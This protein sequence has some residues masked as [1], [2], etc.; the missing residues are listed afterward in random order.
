MLQQSLSQ[1]ALVAGTL[2]EGKAEGKNILG[3]ELLFFLERFEKREG[4]VSVDID[5]QLDGRL[6]PLRVRFELRE[7]EQEFVLGLELG[8]LFKWR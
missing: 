1:V 3:L 5:E 4:G 7:G 6:W 2:G 8:E